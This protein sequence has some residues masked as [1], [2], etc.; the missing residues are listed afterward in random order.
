MDEAKERIDVVDEEDRPVR[1]LSRG[2][3]HLRGFM[4]R[5]VHVFLLDEEERI[6]LQRRAWTKQQDPGLWD[7]SASGHVDSGESYDAAV[8]RE[9]E[10]ELGIRVP[11]EP[12]F[13]MGACPETSHEHSMLYRGR[14]PGGHPVPR[15]NP[16]E[17]LEGR[18]VSIQQ[19]R[20]EIAADPGSFASSFRHL[21]LRYLREVGRSDHDFPKDAS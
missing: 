19:V 3:V 21:F 17:I 8:G 16:D 4:H 18:F 13:K 1:V 10:E 11:L 5:S 9:L 14:L 12:V 2:E 6:F 7:S 20:K 15:I